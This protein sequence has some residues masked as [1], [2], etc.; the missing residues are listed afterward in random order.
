M[1]KRTANVRC[2]FDGAETALHECTNVLIRWGVTPEASPSKIKRA[3]AERTNLKTL[4]SAT[5]T[6]IR[7]THTWCSED[8]K[9]EEVP[10]TRL[11]VLEGTGGTRQASIRTSV[12]R[13]STKQTGTSVSLSLYR[14]PT[15]ASV[16]RRVGTSLPATDRV[17]RSSGA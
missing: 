14:L 3:S 13:S 12:T 1:I 11:F 4:R 2:V 7:P 8:T 10:P 6:A 9:S 5:N 17:K 16:A 15:P